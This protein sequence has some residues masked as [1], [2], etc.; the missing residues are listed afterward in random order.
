MKIQKFLKIIFL[1]VLPCF[2]MVRCA[3]APY[4]GRKQ[5]SLLP[6]S[7]MNSMGSQ[8]FDQ[9][10]QQ[11]PTTENP[12]VVRYIKCVTQPIVDHLATQHSEMKN[13]R[14]AVLKDP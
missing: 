8:A 13:W 4:S 9:M 7:Q 11:T 3:T 6:A 1:Y 14:L 2:F 5:L 10:L 12:A